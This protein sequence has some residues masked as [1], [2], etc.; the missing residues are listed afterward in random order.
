MNRLCFEKK[1]NDF[2][3]LLIE[4]ERKRLYVQRITQNSFNQVRLYHHQHT[5]QN[6]YLISSKVHEQFDEYPSEE[7]LFRKRL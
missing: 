4:L 6:L 7:F 1:K 5:R 2:C 3:F